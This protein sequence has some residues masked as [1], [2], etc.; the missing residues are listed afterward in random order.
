M[1]VKTARCIVCG[2]EYSL[3][4][5]YTCSH[6]GGVLDID[7]D[8]DKLKI[9]L[10]KIRFGSSRED[11]IWKYR[12]LLPVDETVRP[13]SLAE[14]GTGLLRCRRLAEDLGL[15]SALY[16]KDETTEPT[17]SYKDRA[18]S[19]AITK[20]LG[21]GMEMVVTASSGNAGAALAA[22]AA[23][24]GLRNLV[25]VPEATPP[26]KLVQILIHG[27]DVVAVE[28]AYS[29]A[30]QLALC[31]PSDLVA[32]TFPPRLLAHIQLREIRPLHMR[33]QNNLIGTCLIGL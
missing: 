22:Y 8:Y 10:S 6:C 17:G 11:G 2:K 1:S 21:F 4:V 5:I 7:Y 23:K 3:K 30:H 18:A 28:G 31:A 26:E 20:A 33:S 24:A 15:R 29:S 14:G 12:C 19:V 16:V 13:V 25:F 32:L 27:A 9:A